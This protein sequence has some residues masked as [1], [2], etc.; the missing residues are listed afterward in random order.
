MSLFI[1]HSSGVNLT[2][3]GQWYLSRTR[4][5]LDQIREAGEEAAAFGRA[6][7][8]RLKI[9]LFSKL[10]SGFLADLF[11]RYDQRYSGVHIDFV[12]APGESHAAAIRRFD[13]DAAFILSR[14]DW[15]DCDAVSLWS[16][17]LFFAL[18]REHL[19]IGDK[20][21]VQRAG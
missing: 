4:Q 16:K 6:E 12:E 11:H 10:A 5:A 17:P 14:Q 2:L 13:L 19:G 7:D 3:A 18:P 15:A 21:A 20:V 9:G 8:G 1:R